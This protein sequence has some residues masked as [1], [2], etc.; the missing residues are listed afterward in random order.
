VYCKKPK[1]VTK[2][3]A[4]LHES[5]EYKYDS[6]AQKLTVRFKGATRLALQGT[7]SLFNP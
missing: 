2:N 7:G 6:G 4:K 1:E 5:N 3:G